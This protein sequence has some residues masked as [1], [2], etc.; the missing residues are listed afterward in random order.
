MFYNE[1][2]FLLIFLLEMKKSWINYFFNKSSKTISRRKFQICLCYLLIF[3]KNIVSNKSR[4]SRMCSNWVTLFIDHKHVQKIE[5]EHIEKRISIFKI[6]KT[7]KIYCLDLQKKLTIF[8]PKT[9]PVIFLLFY[10]QIFF[11]LTIM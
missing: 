5:N 8:M 2:Q 10:W 7:K 6:S 1:S 3:N 4:K 9:N 11:K